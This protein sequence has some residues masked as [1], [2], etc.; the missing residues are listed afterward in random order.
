MRTGRRIRRRALRTGVAV[1]AV[2]FVGA[3]VS[4]PAT[5]APT[6][7]SPT[8]VNGTST[9]SVE[10]NLGVDARGDVVTSW[11]DYDDHRLQAAAHPAGGGWQPAA[12]LS[13]DF[14][15]PAAV[16]VGGAGDATA[17]WDSGDVGKELAATEQ[18]GGPW[19][20]ATLFAGNGNQVS[21]PSVAA[22]PAGDT[23]VAFNAQDPAT[24]N[25][26]LWA[27]LKPAEGS[28]QTAAPFA[29]TT[30]VSRQ[31]PQVI[32]DD[33]GDTLAWWQATD[34]END[35]ILQA[36]FRPAGGTW[37]PETTVSTP[38]T[39]T[40]WP[41]MTFTPDGTAYAAWVDSDSDSVMTSERPAGGAWTTPSPVPGTSG[42]FDSLA[43]GVDAAGN[44]TLLWAQISGG[45]GTMYSVVTTTGRVG[46]PWSSPVTL[47]GPGG[48][49]PGPQLAVDS[50]GRA[51][52][53][54]LSYDT[55]WTSNLAVRPP[56]QDWQPAI[57]LGA[58]DD[59]ASSPPRVVEDPGGDIVA[60]YNQI[61]PGDI[62]TLWVQAYDGAGP[63]MSGASIP[64]AGT[65]G[66]PV[67]FSVSPLDAWSP[68]TETDWSFGDGTS[69]VD[70]AVTHTYTQPGTYTVTISAADTLGN[71]G[72][73]SGTITIS[74]A[75]ATGA[76]GGGG[77]GAPPASFAPP[78][79][80]ILSD[81]TQ[82]H[83]RWR[84]GSARATLARVQ[85][86]RPPVGTRFTFALNAAAQIT[87]TFTDTAAGRRVGRRC[88]AAS[89]RNRRAP[90]CRRTR[91]RGAFT[92]AV[93]AGSHHLV[94]EGRIGATRLPPGGYTVA[95]Q[96]RGAAGAR[97]QTR[98]L[99]FTIVD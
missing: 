74:P 69:A 44:V 82:S 45:N 42:R 6:W 70:E 17:T 58:P 30:A 67:T 76:A 5:A 88:I 85:P 38:G 97:S 57:A 4:M 68:V 19:Q 34:A 64:T 13:G 63:Y 43:L 84:D 28:W 15:A 33:A 92:Y 59:S 75:P 50:A 18:D 31:D 56:G 78:A 14:G 21:T 49:E 54:W 98:T 20:T 35:T 94:F 95:L 39:S 7:L 89:A 91:T 93:G 10:P 66:V 83:A 37:Q 16:A 62:N 27:A 2:A 41:S 99:R 47:A 25:W 86:A 12:N 8:A 9:N 61:T 32:M 51:V 55:S 1:A 72:I 73:T 40:A 36:A 87:F 23:I 79:S 77:A 3:L 22:D 81:V 53:T 24:G 90:A 52:A 29:T 48:G 26:Y 65:V 60:T 11:V 71:P 96:A 80:L 46:G